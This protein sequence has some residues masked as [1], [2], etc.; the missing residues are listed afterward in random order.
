[1]VGYD[2]LH[3]QCFY[4]NKDL[5]LFIKLTKILISI[6]VMEINLS[7]LLSSGSTAIIMVVNVPYNITPVS[8]THLTLPTKA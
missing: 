2:D 6:I 3:S 5:I 4:M 7:L 1:M 8:Y